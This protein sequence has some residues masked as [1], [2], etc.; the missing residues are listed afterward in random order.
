MATP[1]L[2]AGLLGVIALLTG[3]LLPIER[4]HAAKLLDSRRRLSIAPPSPTPSCKRGLTDGP[5]ADSYAVAALADAA[6]QAPTVKPSRAVPLSLPFDLRLVGL[7]VVSVVLIGLVRFPEPEPPPPPP[8]RPHLSLGAHELEERRDELKQLVDDAKESKDEE[9]KKFTEELKKLYDAIE[10]QKLTR[11]EAFEKIAAL[12]KK[13]FKGMD[14]DFEHLRGKVQRMGGQL[15]KEKLTQELGKALEKG[16]FERAKREAQKLA[17]KLES[18]EKK[19]KLTPPE[20]KRLQ[21]ALERAAEQE[22][23][24]EEQRREEL[25]REIRSSSVSRKRRSSPPNARRSS[26]ARSGS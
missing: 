23:K 5:N 6:R 20:R 17:E 19:E 22:R 26:S 15:S 3:F 2:G 21:R 24:P 16:D 7:L 18:P 12:E 14:G 8:K 9:L 1:G 11:K 4:A 25:R 13:F 10:Q